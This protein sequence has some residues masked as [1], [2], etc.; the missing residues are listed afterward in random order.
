MGFF[1]A[2]FFSSKAVKIA[3]ESDKS[4]NID[5]EK[6]VSGNVE[7][8]PD[9]ESITTD[10]TTNDHIFKDPVIAERYREI[11]ESTNYECR[12]YVDH[13]FTWTP[14][15]E[16]TAVWKNDW[17]VTFWAFVMF[18]ALDID[19]GN[20]SQAMSDNFLKDLKLTTNDYNLGNTLFLV[21]F[22]SAELPSQ[23]LSKWIGPDIWIPAQMVLWSVV[24]VCQCAIQNKAGFL[25]TRSL[26]GALQGGFIPDVGLWM[27]YFY[28]SKELPFRISLFYIANPLS[29]VWSSLLAF[30]LLKIKTHAMRESWRWLFLIEGLVTLLIGIVSFFKMPASVVQT[31]TWYRKKGW[32]TDREEKIIVNKVLRDDPAKGDMNNRQPVGPKELVKTLLNFDLWPIYFVRI[33]GDIGSSPV[34]TYM[35][36]TLRKLGFST[37]KTNALTIPCNV[38]SIFTMLLTGYLS[39]V[40]NQRAMAIAITPVWVL[41]CIIP[42]R[43][44]KKAQIDV[45]GTY[46]LLVVMQSHASV[47]PIT[48]SWCSA[49]S[50]S[51]R[52]RAVSGALVN[53]FSQAGAVISAN[54]YRK[55]DAP[56]YHRGNTDL[57]AI[58]FAALAMCIAAKAYYIFRNSQK[59]RKWNAMTSRE[60]AEYLKMTRDEGHM[61][62]DFRFVH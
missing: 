44:W 16:R 4:I 11:Y 3:N 53:M 15:E 22:L 25:V 26:L 28:T 38:M 46:A 52:A 58:A 33:L 55:D 21:C 57:I 61:R 48:I 17:Y 60:K 10:E 51:V 40:L 49:N 42:L 41:A 45:W 50:N 19:R 27:S 8:Y 7:I 31:K 39:E 34:G 56:L 37:F 30:A 35:T 24:A 2:Q 12:N 59:S 54:I 18:T 32:Y 62:L 13:D 23:L 43:F 20:L 29:A 36:L 6:K 14:Q 9:L 5:G 47:A 1:I